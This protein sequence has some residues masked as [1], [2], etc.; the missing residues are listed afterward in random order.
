MVLSNLKSTFI[1]IIKVFIGILDNIRGKLRNLFF[2]IL[3][4]YVLI[5]D[6]IRFDF[7]LIFIL[8]VFIGIL[9]ESFEIQFSATYL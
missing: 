5:K 6:L 8:K 2:V 7:F 9:G 1:F 3:S 4:I